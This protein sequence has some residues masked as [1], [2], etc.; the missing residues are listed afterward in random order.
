MLATIARM[1][2]ASPLPAIPAGVFI[3]SLMSTTIQHIGPAVNRTSRA[4]AYPRDHDSYSCPLGSTL[5]GETI[6]PSTIYP[7]LG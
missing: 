3:D 1:A 4:Y 5:T 6:V 2:L 7:N